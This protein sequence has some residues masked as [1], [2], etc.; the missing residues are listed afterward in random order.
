[1]KAYLLAC[2]VVAGLTCSCA[3]EQKQLLPQVVEADE[4]TA[5]LARCEAI[6][7]QGSWQFV[8]E[9][10]FR[11]ADGSRGNALGVV[12]LDGQSI[13]SALMTVE[14][15][16]LFEASS[17][18][19]DNLEVKRAIPPFDKAAFATGLMRDVRTLFLLPAGKGKH[20]ILADGTAV[21][22]YVAGETVADLAPLDDGCWRLD[23]YLGQPFDQVDGGLLTKTYDKHVRTRMVRAGSCT[24]GSAAVI[25]KVLELTASGPAGYTLTMR[26]ISAERLSDRQAY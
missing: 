7:P 11:M 22:R 26:L 1:M 24:A 15:L 12:V 3:L 21:C 17:S 20:G 19:A 9:V 16:T 13:R 5:G 14:G 25:P 6:F 4:K 18:G 23:I 2:L 8:H 10:A